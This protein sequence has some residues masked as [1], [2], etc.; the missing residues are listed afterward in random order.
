MWVTT[1][2][3]FLF[4]YFLA[5]LYQRFYLHE[6]LTIYHENTPR[7]KE[8][9]SNIPI[10]KKGYTPTI[11]AISSVIH[12]LISNT[13]RSTEDLK[14]IREEITGSNG[15]HLT[16]DVIEKGV[17]KEDTPTIFMVPGIGG[18]SQKQY[19]KSFINH[20]KN[21]RIVVFN[22]PGS[23]NTK[24]KIKDV[25]LSGDVT[26]VEEV[27]NHLQKKYTKTTFIGIG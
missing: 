5:Y 9:I 21:Q 11:W 13:L 8:W 23:G 2:L 18:H 19:I 17:C 7:N 3:T 16:Y 14:Y 15:Q 4:L 26:Y 24:L 27:L 1:F 20:V 25:H 12:G 6:K 22:H 10:L